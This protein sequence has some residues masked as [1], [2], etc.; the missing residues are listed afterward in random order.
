[1]LNRGG[2]AIG[3]CTVCVFACTVGSEFAELLPAIDAVFSKGATS[4]T[5][6]VRCLPVSKC[7][8]TCLHIAS[9]QSVAPYLMVVP[10]DDYLN[11][12]SKAVT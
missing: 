1:V 5:H 9:R 3:I 7:L 6:Q 11:L 2:R 12:R 10:T 4:T 8:G